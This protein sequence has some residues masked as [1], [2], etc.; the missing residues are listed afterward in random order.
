MC[1]GR[2][3]ECQGDIPRATPTGKPVGESAAA[4]GNNI[5]TCISSS[6]SPSDSPCT[7][8]RHP[9]RDF[10]STYCLGALTC[11]PPGET[12]LNARHFAL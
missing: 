4:T 2:V 12:I 5:R 8:P 7:T 10:S 9:Y 11:G 1:G 3:G 6:Y